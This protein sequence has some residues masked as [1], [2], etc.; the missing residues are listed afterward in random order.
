MKLID[1]THPL[2]HGQ[3]N[4]AWDPKISIVT[5][6]T[7]ATVGYN[8]TQISLSTHQ[9]THL[10][11]PYHFFDDGATVDQVPLDRFYG[12]AVLVDLA[13]G[14]ALRPRTPITPP[15]FAP[16]AAK[17]VKGAKVI[18]RTG[19]DRMFGKPGFLSDFPSLTVEAARWIAE[20]RIGLLGMDS[21]TPSTEWKEVHHLLLGKG[22][23]MVL[24][25]GLANLGQLPERFTFVGFPLKLKGRDG[26]PIRAVAI[27]D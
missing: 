13:P 12:P 26:S 7:T 18:Y 10:D 1:L 5:H 19:W 21:M 11:V 4:F 8:I 9:G 16:H 17:F 6:N 2:E 24:I 25:E 23:E 20:R 22:T 27:G 15:M 3:A 14:G